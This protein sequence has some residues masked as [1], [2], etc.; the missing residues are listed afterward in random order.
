MERKTDISSTITQD[1]KMD[2]DLQ[3]VWEQLGFKEYV[4][5]ELAFFNELSVKGPRMDFGAIFGAFSELKER[6]LSITGRKSM[7]VVEVDHDDLHDPVDSAYQEPWT[8]TS[9]H[10]WAYLTLKF[11]CPQWGD[12]ELRDQFAFRTQHY[13]A[14]FFNLDSESQYPPDDLPDRTVESGP[15]TPPEPGGEKLAFIHR[16]PPELLSDIFIC[17]HDGLLYFPVIIS[18]VDSRFRAIA[19]S[20]AALWTT[21]DVNLPLPFVM[22][23]L[24]NSKASLLDVRMDVSRA[25]RRPQTM[26]RLETIMELLAGEQARMRSLSILGL[27]PPVVDEIASTMLS[28]RSNYPQLKKLDTGCHEWY[29]YRRRSGDPLR[30]LVVP[31]LVQ[32]LCLRGYRTRDWIHGFAV[33]MMELKRFHLANNSGLALPDLLTA[34]RNLPNLSELIIDTCRMSFDPASRKSVTSATLPKLMTLECLL[35]NWREMASVLRLLVTPSL[36]SLK[37]WW[38]TGWKGLANQAVGLVAALQAKPQLQTLDLCNFE[39]LVPQWKRVFEGATSIRTLR[40]RS[41]ELVEEDLRGLWEPCVEE[42][43]VMPYLE[44]LALE[45]VLDLRTGVVRWI[46]ASRPGL[47]SV[48]LRGWGRDQVDEEDVEFVRNSVENFVLETFGERD[49]R[50][51]EEEMSDSDEEEW[52]SWGSPSQGSWLSGDQE[53]VAAR[54]KYPP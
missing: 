22:L 8:P 11:H 32:H 17:A 23:Y 39:E 47:R 49:P 34:L 35:L 7:E 30:Y 19:E 53:V 40:L 12:E 28:D 45:N 52:S 16:L 3:D 5:E 50:D 6:A 1:P 14:I 36:T 2:S 31:L 26:S 41:C 21:V 46:I 27:N 37:L 33:P 18:H 51:P 29:G 54:Y 48:E 24:Q 9:L 4:E 15:A 43:P 38:E 42:A 44:H 20:T 10:R 25:V 13:D